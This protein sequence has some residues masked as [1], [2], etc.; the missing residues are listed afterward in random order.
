[1]DKSLRKGEEL[2]TTIASGSSIICWIQ[3]RP[4][5]EYE[6]RHAWDVAKLDIYVFTSNLQSG[7]WIKAE[8]SSENYFKDV[9]LDRYSRHPLAGKSYQG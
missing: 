6:R 2:F 1:M 8:K 9:N 5:Q 7:F 3:L 4:M